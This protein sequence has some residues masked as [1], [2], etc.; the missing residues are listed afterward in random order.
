MLSCGSLVAGDLGIKQG[1]QWSPCL[2][3]TVVNPIWS[4]NAFDVRATVEFTHHS[5]GEKR[6]TE[7]YFVGEKSWAFRFTATETGTWS[8]LTSSEDEDLHGHTGTVEIVANPRAGAHGFLKQ[9][10]NKWGWKGAENAFVP[11]LVMWDFIT[12]RSNPRD[13][14][15]QPELVDRMIERFIVEHGFNGF[16]VPVIGG[17]W[18]NLDARSDK[19]VSTMTD[20]DPRT[21][22]ALEQLIIRTHA[23]GGMVQIPSLMVN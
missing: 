2:E 20:P 19:V 16:H 15:N 22:K 21:F 10:G 12:G 14:H 3:W 4:G 5:S 1:T 17:R 18:F 11:Q 23:A 13:F 9:F 6:R 7:M 8:F